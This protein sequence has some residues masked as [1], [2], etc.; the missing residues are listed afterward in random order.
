MSRVLACIDGSSYTS[1]VC[2][3]AQWL[4]GRTNANVK[5]LHVRDPAA[6]DAF[7]GD[8]RALVDS[9]VAELES[10]GATEVE[11]ELVEGSF[12]DLAVEFAAAMIVIGKRGL[13]NDAERGR[14]GHSVGPLVRAT[15]T[16]ICLAPR[17]FLPVERAV[18]ILDAD[19]AHRRTV[20]FLGSQPGL[21]ELSLDL[22]VA[23]M[24]EAAHPKVQWAR[25]TLAD[26]EAEI[27]A[28]EAEGTDDGIRRYM[29][30]R[31]S[32]LIII[33]RAVLMGAADGPL[34]AIEDQDIWG[35]RTPVLIC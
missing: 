1:S 21:R 15:D 4:A 26:R 32:D 8:P 31:K 10:E 13:A 30:S 9:A 17:W 33:S 27:Y 24:G 7:P 16:P 34:R 12:P 5:V 20:E 6:E 28:V 35:W 3:H 2:D 29:A 22:V 19:M 11:S 25:E 14:L 23:S 18:A